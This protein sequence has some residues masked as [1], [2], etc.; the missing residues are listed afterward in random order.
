M[1]EHLIRSGYILGL[2]RWGILY[3]PRCPG[4]D[5][6]LEP[7]ESAYRHPLYRC[8]A[9]AAADSGG[10]ESGRKDTGGKGSGHKGSG[11]IDR[12]LKGICTACR[13]RL[14]P[15]G[16]QVCM[17]C[18]R[19]LENGRA[20]YCPD[21]RKKDFTRSFRAG[22]SLFL[23]QGAVPGMMYRF[24]YAERQEYAQFFALCAAYAYTDWIRHIRPDVIMPVP[25]YRRKQRR[26]GYNQAAVFGRE[27][28]RIF[29][30]PYTDRCV[31][32]I[33]NTQPMKELDDI[34]RV[35]N[36]TGAFAAASEL[37]GYRSVLLVD[38]IYTTGATADEVSRTLLEAGVG[39]VY[40]LSI[41]IGKGC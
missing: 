32:R 18:G 11:Y 20:E 41:S 36:I 24:K 28:G 34:G 31:R 15:V 3:L 19:P 1:K 26:R 33:R 9:E 40:F 2:N 37:D 22:R 10:K 23:Y 30:I 21:C 6:L 35:R 27:L 39:C 25:M 14:Q 17:H 16:S 8:G 5:G 29:G 4:C 7:E 12:E 13:Q 38:D